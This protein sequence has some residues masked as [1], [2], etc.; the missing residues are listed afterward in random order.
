MTYITYSK[1]RFA[2]ELDESPGYFKRYTP[3]PPADKVPSTLDRP[4]FMPSYLVRTSDM[5]VVQSSEVQEGYCALSYSW[6]QSGKVVKNVTTGNTERN[7][8][9]KHKIVYPATRL[10]KILKFLKLT[11]SVTFEKVIQ[12]IC[13]DFNIK[14]IWYDQMCINQND[15]EEKRCEIRQMHKI[16]KNAHCTIALVPELTKIP[17]KP[18]F[19]IRALLLSIILKRLSVSELVTTPSVLELVT[20]QSTQTMV[21]TKL[22]SFVLGNDFW[23]YEIDYDHFLGSQW[24]KRMWTLEETL[25]SRNMLFVG[26]YVNCWSNRMSKEIFPICHREFDCDVATILHYA[27]ARTSTKEHDR[28]FALANIFPEIMEQITIDYNQ[29]IEEL[30]MRFYYLLAKKDLS[31]LCFGPYTDHGYKTMCKTA[32]NNRGIEDDTKRGTENGIPIKKY[33]LPSWTGVNGEHY[34]YGGYETCMNNYMVIEET[35][36]VTCCGIPNRRYY[37][38]MLDFQSIAFEDIPSLPQQKLNG[39]GCWT[40]VIRLRLPD[41]S[42]EKLI[43]LYK[44]R[45]GDTQLFPG[46][47]VDIMVSIPNLSHFF[48]IKKNLQWI[49]ESSDL[50]VAWFS[51]DDLT[52]VFQA[53]R[54]YVILTGVRFTTHKND[55]VRYPVIKRNQDYYEAIG[56]CSVKDDNHFFDDL[57]LEERMFEIR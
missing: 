4:Q 46:A 50:P 36:Q 30:M 32:F 17:F 57:I 34:K 56:M 38:E 31:I 48:Q 44:I 7:D 42:N 2:P 27:H 9:G 53:D 18:D 26:P 43:G 8:E 24:M 28:V 22:L 5:V 10:Q 39:E 25:L 37:T 55:T 49:P 3:V 45:R 11:K 54:Q 19:A 6:N 40:L 13:K 29:D 33:D 52:E 12:E 20:T 16:Y 23:S 47:Y 51:F 1:K 21:V 41:S 35:L 15:D 14:Y